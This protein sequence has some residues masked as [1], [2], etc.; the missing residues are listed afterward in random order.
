MTEQRLYRLSCRAAR[1]LLDGLDRGDCEGVRR[2][3]GVLRHYLT[4]AE[5]TPAA[6]LRGD[7]LYRREQ[8][9][10]LGA[11]T[12]G[13]NG[14]VELDTTGAN[15]LLLQHLVSRSIPEPR[16]RAAGCI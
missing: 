10:L 11:V 12:E 4:L 3:L 8:L 7:A 1:E 2:K 16:F 14:A 13:M 5:I 6:S 15:R 9:E